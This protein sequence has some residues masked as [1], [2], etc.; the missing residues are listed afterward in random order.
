MTEATNERVSEET[1]S[2]KVKMGCLVFALIAFVISWPLSSMFGVAYDSILSAF[3]F[4][5]GIGILV[6]LKITQKSAPS[7][8]G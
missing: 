4:C 6:V 5:G 1:I 8:E 7:E 3:V 2:A